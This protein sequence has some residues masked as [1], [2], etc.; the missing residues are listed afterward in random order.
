MSDSTR[1]IPAIT[2]W[3]PWAWA[4]MEA[5]KDIENRSW[6]PPHS[7]I[8]RRIAIHAAARKT[9]RALCRW[10]ENEFD[11]PSV[12]RDLPTGCVLGTVILAGVIDPHNEPD[13]WHERGFWGW[14]L[15]APK[16]FREPIP[17]RGYQR[18]WMWRDA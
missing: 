16:P 6:R 11:L 13:G 2:I 1:A 18:I 7:L 5:G 8:G 10:I 17:A 12:P 4:I 15:S 9:D 3:Q 14:Q